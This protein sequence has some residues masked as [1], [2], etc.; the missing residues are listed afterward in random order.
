MGLKGP[1]I[2]K[3]S[4]TVNVFRKERDMGSVTQ[5][6]AMALSGEDAERWRSLQTL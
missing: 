4:E 1:G 6:K 5:L 3:W 2:L